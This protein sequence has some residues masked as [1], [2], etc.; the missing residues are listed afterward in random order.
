MNAVIHASDISNPIKNF[1]VYSKWVDR[2]LQEFWNQVL[3]LFGIH[4]WGDW[5]WH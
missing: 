3:K 4:I 5:Q 2:V 1:G